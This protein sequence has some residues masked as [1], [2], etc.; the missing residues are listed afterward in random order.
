MPRVLLLVPTASYR[1]PDF[2]DAARSLGVELVVGSEEQPAIAGEGTQWIPIDDPM[3]AA[4]VI[5]ALDR[6]HGIDAVVAVDDQGAVAAAEA[7][8]RLGFP[9][10]DPGA[11]AAT[12]DKLEM[13]RRLAGGEI[14]QPRFASSADGVGYP[15]VVKPTGLAA[16]RGVIRCDNPAELERA[17]ARIARFWDGPTI[18]EEYVPGVEIALEGLLDAGRLTVLAIFDKP[19]PLVGPYFEET[20]YVTPTRLEADVVHDVERLVERGAR[21]IGLEEGPIHAEVRVDG[22]R[23]WLI[24]VAARSIGGLCARTLRF[25]AGISLEEVVLRHALGM[26]LDELSRESSA[27]GVMMLP[28]PRGGTLRAV[29]G[30]EAALSVRGVVG[31]EIT[32]P[33]GHR[34][35]P[36]PEGDRYLGFVFARATS[37][38]AVES[39]LRAAAEKLDIVIS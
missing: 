38:E 37:P 19:D 20:I 36:L 35:E 28:I 31:I 17:K 10:S 13:R 24:E 1:A 32:I 14:S 7:G 9:H 33:I 18:V 23:M 12:R 5:G 21:A 30:R 27:S 26:P 25:G 3:H 8:A 15:C 22:D 11:V 4:D 29:E 2:V 39:A 34:V 16:S 6:A